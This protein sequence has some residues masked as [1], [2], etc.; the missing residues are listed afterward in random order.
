[1][2]DLRIQREN[3]VPVSNFLY[4]NWVICDQL[5]DGTDN[6][7]PICFASL[8]RDQATTTSERKDALRQT[9]S[10]NTSG[11]SPILAANS[12]RLQM[13][14]SSLDSDTNGDTSLLTVSNDNL[15]QRQ[16]QFSK[17]L[18][19]AQAQTQ[20]QTQ[21]Q[22][23]CDT[24]IQGEDS[25]IKP[26]DVGPPVMLPC[27]HV[28]HEACIQHWTR[29]HN[30][31]P[32]CRFCPSSYDCW[33]LQAL[34]PPI[35]PT[36]TAGIEGDPSQAASRRDSR[37]SQT[38]QLRLSTQSVSLSLA[39]LSNDRGSRLPTIFSRHDQSLSNRNIILPTVV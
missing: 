23:Q 10:A 19:Q 14:F 2:R 33:P 30:S 12:S 3:E 26:E 15:T 18:T 36:S 29:S 1:M 6:L 21:T 32:L 4:R 35:L 9:V 22:T 28:F 34:Y 37:A 20:A 16:R 38:N 11:L 27:Q 24:G 39:H 25:D 5:P 17:S 7:C 31:C 8:F 13:P